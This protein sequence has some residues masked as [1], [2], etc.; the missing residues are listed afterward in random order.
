MSQ[1][2]AHR[3]WRLNPWAGGSLGSRR[4]WHSKPIWLHHLVPG[5]HDIQQHLSLVDRQARPSSTHYNHSRQTPSSFMESRHCQ[6]FLFTDPV[7]TGLHFPSVL[8]HNQGLPWFTESSWCRRLLC[9]DIAI[10]FLLSIFPDQGLNCFV[11]EN[12][13]VFSVRF[14]E[15]SLFQIDELLHFIDSHRKFIKM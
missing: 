9:W 6:T 4:F 10:N 12:S 7:A 2:H 5:V 13:R 1:R 11:L 3:Q 14:P 8:L 15:F